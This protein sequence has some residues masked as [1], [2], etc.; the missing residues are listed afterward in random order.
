MNYLV[1]SDNHGDR[2]ILVA[3]KERYQQQV[4]AMFHCGDS[5]LAATDTLWQ[6]FL[7]VRGN[8]DYDDGFPETV[9]ETIGDD[10]IFMTHGHLA[11][12]RANLAT[13]TEQAKH[14]QANLAFFGHTHELLA[15]QNEGILFVNPGSIR[16]PRGRYLY[17]TYAIIQTTPEAYSVQYYT[18]DHQ[19]IADL[20]FTFNK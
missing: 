15:T 10:C 6:D 19:P 12:V 3:L 1:V 8:C 9:V 11:N 20:A 14:V 2:D 5:E 13:L 17:P 4:D 16:L 18:R 7:V